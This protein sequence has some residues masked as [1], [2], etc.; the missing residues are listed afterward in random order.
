MIA[1]GFFL[2]TTAGRHDKEAGTPAIEII[3]R[4]SASSPDIPTKDF[5]LCRS[6]VVVW[7]VPEEIWRGFRDEGEGR[8]LRMS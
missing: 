5:S 4:P 3:L 6:A 2:T 7:R 8:R 1:R